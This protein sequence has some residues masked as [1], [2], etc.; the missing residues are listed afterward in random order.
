M[1][2]SVCEIHSSSADKMFVCQMEGCTVIVQTLVQIFLYNILHKIKQNP[3]SGNKSTC[4]KY[5]R[6]PPL[7][8]SLPRLFLFLFF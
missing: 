1:R 5:G 6:I 2:R 3:D 4:F 7:S 8:L